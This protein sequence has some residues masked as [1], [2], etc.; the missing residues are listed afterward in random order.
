MI[1][2]PERGLDLN[3]KSVAE[4]IMKLAV[5]NSPAFIRANANRAEKLAVIEAL[6]VEIPVLEKELADAQHELEVAKVESESR[7]VVEPVDTSNAK[8]EIA[9]KNISIGFAK[10]SILDLSS[11]PA[12][13]ALKDRAEKESDLDAAEAFN[14]E[15]LAR[16]GN[17]GDTLTTTDMTSK[18][19]PKVIDPEVIEPIIEPVSE[20]SE[21]EVDAELPS[22]PFD[23][24]VNESGGNITTAA[25]S[26]FKEEL[27]GK[28]VKTVIGDVHIIGSTF[29]EMK[30]NTNKDMIKARLISHIVDILKNGQYLGKE[31]LNKE[32]NDSF[33]AFHFFEM[34]GL[35]VG[36]YTVNAGVT[37]AQRKEG[38]LEF[39]L[40]AYGLGHSLEKRWLKRK[41]ESVVSGQKP[42]IDSPIEP[43]KPVLDST[44]ESDSNFV[45]III[46]KVTDLDGNEITELEDSID[47]DPESTATEET[48]EQ[49][50]QQTEVEKETEAEGTEASTQAHITTLQNIVD[51]A[52]D[53]DDLVD[54]LDTL[55]KAATA[56]I[57]AGLGEENDDLIGKAADKY[58][59][60]DFLKY[61][62]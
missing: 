51:G 5:K 28:V 30:R 48:N 14:A 52:H 20:V 1:A 25:K 47:K 39:D 23:D 15:V 2:A 31:G 35:K 21:Q 16:G 13:Q 4:R 58:A 60:L 12:L 10:K 17:K 36:E 29:S 54:L 50:N 26:Y 11:E 3:V 57:D 27:K 61:G 56:L 37:V 41:G 9:R 22:K 24:Y 19:E 59:A 44:I 55:D 49:T 34:D 42:E 40:S 6:K 43:E 46:L 8:L 45:N 53:N 7:V 18:S 33:I 32:R 38:Q 62:N